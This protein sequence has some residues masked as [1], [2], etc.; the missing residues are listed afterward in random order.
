M[1]GSID[2]MIEEQH[3]LMH[4]FYQRWQKG[5]VTPE[6]L[7]SY[8]IQYYAYESA[9][10][11]FLEKAMAHLPAG[12]ALESLK[13]NLA[14]EAGGPV[15][16]PELWL[17]FAG[18]LG[19]S[20]EEVAETPLLPRTT[21]LVYTYESLCDRGADEALAALY[22]YESQFPSVAA[23]KADGLRRFY[24]VTSPEALEFF[25]LHAT[26]DHEHAAGIRNGLV[27]SEPA[28]E[29]AALALDAWWGMLDTFEAMLV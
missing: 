8:A 1:V 11:S 16:H 18:A 26:L 17:R 10:P 15:P 14:D 27:D 3:L 12:P 9:L 22:A 6:V 2:R 25:D 21:N 24:G 28:R 7:R 5:K 19:V 20:R 23:S 13:D 4:P 29:A